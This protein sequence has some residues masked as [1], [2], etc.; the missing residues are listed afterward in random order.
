MTI[1]ISRQE[2][3]RLERIERAAI[4][5]VQKNGAPSVENEDDDVGYGYA[6]LCDAVENVPDGFCAQMENGYTFSDEIDVLI[7][8][9]APGHL[10]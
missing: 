5:F 4:R 1:D 9:E 7:R 8:N 6:G 10:K 2:L 3:A